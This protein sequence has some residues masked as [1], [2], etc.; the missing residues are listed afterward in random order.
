MLVFSK[1][2][3]VILSIPKTGTTA[4]ETALGPSAAIWVQDPPDL[5]HAP[6]YRYNRFFRPAL[7]KFVSPDIQTM[8]VVRE[9]ISWLGS[10]WRYRQRP[11]MEGKANATH[12]I[13]FDDFVE[14]Y[15]QGKPPAF[16]NVGSQA[17]FL[18][19]QPN[20]TSIDLL[21]RYED[22]PKL[23]AFLEERLERPITLA[24]EN[25]SPEIPVALSPAVEAK[26]RR[27]CAAEF[28][29]YEGIA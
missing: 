20:G 3:L 10:W 16:A 12:G 2:K 9:P 15:C 7:E 18:K 6:I 4:I 28:E 29:L 23:L 1:A 26:Y 21:F 11:F 17:N 13:S 19:P 8:A 5:K 27:K 25:V 24:R 22:Q 14:A